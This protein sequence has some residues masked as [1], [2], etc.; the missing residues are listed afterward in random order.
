V[1][2]YLARGACSLSPHIALVESG[3]S[4]ETE[5]V[6]LRSKMTAG[7]QDY[8]QINPKGSVACRSG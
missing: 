8:R 3:L 6:D 4:F 7:G 5:K 1:K 2:L